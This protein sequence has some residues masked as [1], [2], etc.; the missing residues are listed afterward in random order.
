MEKLLAKVLS[1]GKTDNGLK[2][3]GLLEDKSDMVF[4]T[5]QTVLS[6]GSSAHGRMKREKDMDVRFRN[7]ER[8]KLDS[9]RMGFINIKPD[10][11]T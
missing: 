6:L 2:E 1:D 7:Q 4:C 8:L 11:N 10:S 5:M 3:H 9:G